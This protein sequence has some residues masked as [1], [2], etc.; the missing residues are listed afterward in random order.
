MAIGRNQNTDRF[1]DYFVS[2][3][4]KKP[5]RLFVPTGDYFIEHCLE[6]GTHFCIYLL[7]T[8]MEM[9]TPAG[10]RLMNWES[11]YGDWQARPDWATLRVIPWLEKTALVLADAV[12]EESGTEIAVAPRTILRRQIERA[13]ARGLRAKMA[14]E[15]EFYL[16]SDSYDAAHAAGY[17]GLARAGWPAWLGLAAFAIHLGWQI[18]R[19]QIDDPALCLRIFKSNRDAGLLLFAGL[20]TDAVMR[21]ALV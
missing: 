6:H 11:G 21:A 5:F 7:G 3:I 14:S 8:E 16:L 15:L 18:T 1:T 13:A 2:P 4:A 10:Y 17:Q 20:L 9:T 19:L 12:E